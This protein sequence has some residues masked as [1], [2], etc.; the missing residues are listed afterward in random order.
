MSSRGLHL[1]HGL[2]R[3]GIHAL[4]CDVLGPDRSPLDTPFSAAVSG[5][6][7]AG[8]TT[9]PS[10]KSTSVGPSMATPYPDPSIPRDAKS[11]RYSARVAGSNQADSNKA[12][13]ESRR[14]RGAWSSAICL[15]MM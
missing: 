10:F 7:P 4:P 13:I 11:E 14:S 6:L 15:D 12:S 1:T 2:H 9:S 8:P 5:V 3:S